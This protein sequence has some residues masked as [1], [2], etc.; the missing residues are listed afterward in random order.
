MDV[1]RTLGQAVPFSIS[2]EKLM[3]RSKFAQRCV[4]LFLLVASSGFVYWQWRT[5]LTEGYYYPKA[6]GIFSCMAVLSVAMILFP[7]DPDEFLAAHG[8]D[9][10]QNFR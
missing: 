8:V 9:R 5:L 6:A 3:L 10:I 7:I 2:K 4:G 1:S